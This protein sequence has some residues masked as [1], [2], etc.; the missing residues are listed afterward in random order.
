MAVSAD[1]SKQ[2][3]REELPLVQELAALHKWEITADYER[4]LVGAKLHAHNGDLFLVEIRCDNYKEMPPFFE[5]IEPESGARGTKRAYPKTTDSLFHESGPCIC[6]PFNRKAYKSVE[7]S[8]PHGDW[9][10]SD[11]MTSTASSVRWSNYS[12]L[13]DMLGLIQTRL[14]RPD[15]YRGRMG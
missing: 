10:F 8:A 6:A 5:F 4:L 7:P 15:F 12:T 14:G 3:M 9:Q 1:V 13:A 11:W 2:Y